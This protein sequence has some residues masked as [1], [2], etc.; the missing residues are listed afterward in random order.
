MSSQAYLK[1]LSATEKIWAGINPNCRQILEVV[2]KR[3][4]VSPYKVQD[5]IGMGEIASQA[6]LHK[7]LTELVQSNY[8]ALKPDPTDGRV[9]FVTLS[10]KGSLLVDKL[11]KLLSQ[12][13]A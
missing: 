1:F 5:V 13:S 11:S 6:T 7:A 9:K 3:D 2:I 8:I 12:S 4:S 10:R